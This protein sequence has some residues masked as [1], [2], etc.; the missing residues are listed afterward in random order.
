MVPLT[1]LLQRGAKKNRV[2]REIGG[3]F[4]FTVNRK[5]EVAL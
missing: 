3:F 5:N 1:T 2:I 4:L